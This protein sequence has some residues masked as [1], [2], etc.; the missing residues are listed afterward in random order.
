[1][2]IESH[3]ISSIENC[4][5]ITL[6]KH[7]H[8]NG[9]LSVVENFKELPFELRRIYYLYDIP[10]GEERGGHSHHNCEEFIIAV[11][12]SFDIILDDGVTQRT[13]NLNR[14]NVGILVK[15]L[16]NITCLSVIS[17]YSIPL[18]SSF[19]FKT[20]QAGQWIVYNVIMLSPFAKLKTSII[21]TYK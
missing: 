4:P 17:L 10:G 21:L 8:E 18:L 2:I 5:I 13:I 15:P 19:F 1:M 7:H 3:K 14:S 11:C 20:L 16:S 6:H 9:N 12:G